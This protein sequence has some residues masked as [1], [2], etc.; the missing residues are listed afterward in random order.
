MDYHQIMRIITTKECQQLRQDLSNSVSLVDALSKNIGG[1]HIPG[2]LWRFFSEYYPKGGITEWNS[3]S[4]WKQEWELPTNILYAFGEDLFGNQLIILHA[5]ENVH[6]WNHENGDVID[7]LLDPA[8]LLETIIQSGIDWIDFYNDESA[9]IAEKRIMD[10]PIESHLHWTTPLILGGRIS[11]ENTSIVERSLH[12]RG[13]A[14]LWKQ[15][16]GY[17]P[18]TIIIPTRKPTE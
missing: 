18:G 2:G 13:H 11:L 8:S 4:G 12:L 1:S 10:V 9:K 17:D 5:V 7:M 3:F 6:L 14:K 15:L 16:S